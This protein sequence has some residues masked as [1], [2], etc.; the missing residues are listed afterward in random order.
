M[1]DS[2]IERAAELLVEARRT[3][4]KLAALPQE[5][6]LTTMQDAHAVQVRA[7]QLAGART[8]AWKVGAPPGSPTTYAPIYAD[9]VHPSGETVS[10]ARY[11]GAMIEGEIGFRLRRDLPQSAR[12]YGK[13]DVA[14]ALDCVCVTM[15]IGVSRYADFGNASNAEK[16][17]DNLGNGALVIGTGRS[18]WRTM[19]LQDLLVTMTVNGRPHL[20]RRG[21]K[22][23][24]PA[25]DLVVWA[26]NHL[27]D[28]DGLRAGQVVTT[29]SWTGT[30]AARA[31]DE[32]RTAFQGV[33]EARLRCE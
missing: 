15:E 26:A 6:R 30:F 11:A 22:P 7:A 23:G 17:A 24:S 4:R 29:G 31:G 8:G 10:L 28:A 9:D 1:M 18:D 21:G 33:G 12:P 14:D 2:R 32:F 13:D 20:E 16:V 25:L 3:G 27:D 5:A 19:D